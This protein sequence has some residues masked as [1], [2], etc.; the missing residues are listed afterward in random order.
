MACAKGTGSLTQLQ[1]NGKFVIGRELCT[2]LSLR[3]ITVILG[4]NREVIRNLAVS[5]DL[6]P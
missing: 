5:K 6:S 4:M 2:N 1:A 3:G